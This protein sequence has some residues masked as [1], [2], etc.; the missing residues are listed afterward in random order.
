MLE[1]TI[2]KQPAAAADL[3]EDRMHVNCH[4]TMLFWRCGINRGFAASMWPYAFKYVSVSHAAKPAAGVI[5]AAA[6][7]CNALWPFMQVLL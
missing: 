2:D 5:I 3:I 7:C 6:Q 4:V 1:L